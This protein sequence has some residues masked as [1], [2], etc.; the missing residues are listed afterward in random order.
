MF[1]TLEM[2]WAFD[3]PAKAQVL[4]PGLMMGVTQSCHAM[5]PH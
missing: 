3:L 4:S 1:L 2:V 5:P